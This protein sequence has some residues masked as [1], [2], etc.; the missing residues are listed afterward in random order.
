MRSQRLLQVACGLTVFWFHFYTACGDQVF[1]DQCHWNPWTNG[2]MMQ[3]LAFSFVLIAGARLSIKL[4]SDLVR[5][6]RR[7][8]WHTAEWIKAPSRQA[9]DVAPFVTPHYG[10]E[11]L[12]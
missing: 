11:L 6:K 4:G 5:W 2:S 1:D 12:F 7:L 8:K 10:R 3:V 9:G